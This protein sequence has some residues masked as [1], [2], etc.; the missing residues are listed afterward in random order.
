MCRRWANDRFLSTEHLAVNLTQE[1]RYLT[2][3]FYT[4]HIDHPIVCLPTCCNAANPATYPPITYGEYR[5]W[6]L[7]N[8]YQANLENPI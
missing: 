8:N 4:P 3:F 7:N 6:W 1:D 5:V 2:P